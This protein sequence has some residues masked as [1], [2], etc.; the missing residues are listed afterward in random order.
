MSPMS[1]TV[2]KRPRP[3]AA[4]KKRPFVIDDALRRVRASVKPFA[5]AAMFELAD[6]GF[7]SPF[8]QLVACIISIRT[9]DEATVPIARRLFETARTPAEISRL[10][11]AQIDALIRPSTFHE[12]KA[13][14]IREIAKRA[15]DKF[16]GEL[17]CDPEVL[18]SFRGVGPKCANLV[19]GN[20]CGRPFISVDIHVHRVTNRWGYVRASTPEKTMAALEA[21]LPRNYWVE[22]NALLMPFGKHVC[23]GVRPK[24][25]TCPVLAM[26]Q[27]VGVTSHR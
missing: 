8:E 11:I 19:L 15:V 5:K 3:L 22:I 2:A 1:R 4:D 10:S 14:Q 24:C 13:A 9:R 17:P 16:A 12:A 21:K 23:T 7:D 26:C 25:S 18:M 27:Q 6:D 20:A